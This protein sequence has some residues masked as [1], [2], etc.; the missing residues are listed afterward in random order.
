M[1]I[2]VMLSNGFLQILDL[3]IYNLP[4]LFR[5]GA[6]SCRHVVRAIAGP[7]GSWTLMTADGVRHDAQ[8]TGG[9]RVADGALI[10]MLW[11]D[12]DRRSLVAWTSVRLQT[13][14][15]GRRLL[16]RLRWPLREPAAIA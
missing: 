7:D 15:V 9:W 14:T 6:S 1:P 11:R 16:V 8:L 10:G 13:D 12:A 2:Y 5:I 4:T 3:R